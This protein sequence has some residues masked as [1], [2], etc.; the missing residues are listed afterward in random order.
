MIDFAHRFCTV[1][2]SYLQQHYVVVVVP[3]VSCYRLHCVLPYW[4]SAIFPITTIIIIIYVCVYTIY[5]YTYNHRRPSVMCVCVMAIG[6]TYYYYYY[7]VNTIKI[8]VYVIRSVYRACRNGSSREWIFAV[9]CGARGARAS[10]RNPRG[11]GGGL[12]IRNISFRR[13]GG[14]VKTYVRPPPWCNSHC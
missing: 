4:V 14:R 2:E 9:V 6:Y 10:L 5:I 7:Y 1:S 12:I 3:S 11:G 13:H 8:I